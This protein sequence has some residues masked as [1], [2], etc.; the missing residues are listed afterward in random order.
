VQADGGDQR[1]E[2]DHSAEL[3]HHGG[4]E[5]TIDAAGGGDSLTDVV[6]TGSHPAAE[7]DG[8]QVERV[9]EQWQ[10]HDG[11]A[12]TEGDQG[13]GDGN[14]VFVGVGSVAHGG[15]RR[16]SAD[17]EPSGDQKRPGPRQTQQPT[18]QLRADESDHHGHDHHGQPAQTE[19]L[20][21]RQTKLQAEENDGEP[22]Q[23]V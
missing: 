10:Q 5:G 6:D 21:L 14:V 1:R 2:Q 11:E 12:A 19:G 22:Q 16:R 17:R 18:E 8:V 13:D 9:L 4:V 3:D 20:E 15:D 7:A 23:A